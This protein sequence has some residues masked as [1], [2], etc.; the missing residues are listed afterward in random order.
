MGD[1]KAAFKEGLGESLAYGPAA[2]IFLFLIGLLIGV[3]V[4]NS[5]VDLES[6]ITRGMVTFAKLRYGSRL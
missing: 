1:F 5:T 6:L 2:L 4:Y 3:G